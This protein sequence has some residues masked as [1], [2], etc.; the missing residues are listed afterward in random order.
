MFMFVPVMVMMVV[1]PFPAMTDFMMNP[2]II[3]TSAE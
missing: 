1:Y 2:S 3:Q